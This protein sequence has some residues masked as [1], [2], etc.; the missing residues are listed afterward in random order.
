MVRTRLKNMERDSGVC[1]SMIHD[2]GSGFS[3]WSCDL[4]HV[5]S[6]A[7]GELDMISWR[8]CRSS[9]R[10][11]F[12]ADS[13]H[14][15]ETQS[16][17]SALNG[18]NPCKHTVNVTAAS[19]SDPEVRSAFS[20]M[21]R[22]GSSSVPSPELASSKVGTESDSS[23]SAELG[24]SDIHNQTSIVYVSLSLYGLWF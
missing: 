15:S 10:K 3:F 20:S 13:W 18:W 22:V 17:F 21:D 16:G 14:F 8:S 5:L 1:E 12:S 19:E 24:R 11:G 23:H 9:G 6:C 4:G 7:V 2:M